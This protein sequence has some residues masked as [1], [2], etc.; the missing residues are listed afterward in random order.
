MKYTDTPRTTRSLH[1]AR[2]DLGLT[3]AFVVYPGTES[4]P[5]ADGVD[6]LA[7]T[8]VPAVRDRVTA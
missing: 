8:D 6:A 5:L 1:I 3:R 4:Y 7:I 2:S